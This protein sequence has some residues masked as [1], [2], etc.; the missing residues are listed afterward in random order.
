MIYFDMKVM[1]EYM[2]VVPHTHTLRVRAFVSVFL[3]RDLLSI[4]GCSETAQQKGR[5]S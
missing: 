5:G 1:N 2:Q 4:S 3:S